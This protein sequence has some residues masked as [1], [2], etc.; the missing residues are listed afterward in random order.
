MRFLTFSILL[1]LVSC[2]SYPKKL[3]YQTTD[4]ASQMIIN[5]YF[6][7]MNR[8]YVYKANITVFKNNFGGILVL[9]S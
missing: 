4:S 8:D 3:G 6:S 5:P 7:D 1:L 2:T 9:K